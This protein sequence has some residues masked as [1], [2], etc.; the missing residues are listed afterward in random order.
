[1]IVEIALLTGARDAEGLLAL[2][3]DASPGGEGRAPDSNK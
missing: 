1:M 3:G 2:A